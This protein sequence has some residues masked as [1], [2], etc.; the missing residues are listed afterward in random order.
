MVLHKES[1]F[2]CKISS[3]IELFW[4]DDREWG[5][6]ADPYHSRK[7]KEVI[8]VRTVDDAF[9]TI[10]KIDRNLF[11]RNCDVQ[12]W[13]TFTAVKNGLLEPGPETIS[14]AETLLGQLQKIYTVYYDLTLVNLDVS[15]VASGTNTR[16]IGL[17]FSTETWFQ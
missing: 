3:L 15:I 5:K 6:T 11:E 4:G 14:E 13:T 10:D 16:L 7:D 2:F 12:A 17:D 8:A 1:V 9:D